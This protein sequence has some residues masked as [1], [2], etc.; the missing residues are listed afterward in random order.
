MKTV[1]LIGALMAAVLAA[2]P[3]T[4]FAG[5]V[6]SFNDN[7]IVADAAVYR[8]SVIMVE[9]GNYFKD[10]FNYKLDGSAIMQNGDWTLAGDKNGNLYTYNSRTKQKNYLFR[11]PYNSNSKYP[12]TNVTMKDYRLCFQSDG[13]IVCYANNDVKKPVYHSSTYSTLTCANSNC[14]YYYFL[15]SDGR[16]VAKR[17][18]R[19]G[20]DTIFDSARCSFVRLV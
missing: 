16:L 18:Y 6:L 5:N 13:N 14:L 10:I 15:E 12:R 1:K 17:L 8:P 4:G 20:V 11:S 19:G 9:P 3:V 2:A 7:A